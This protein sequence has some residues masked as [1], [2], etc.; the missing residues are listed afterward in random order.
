M[1]MM[2]HHADAIDRGEAPAPEFVEFPKMMTH[3]AFEPARPAEEVKLPGGSIQFV[4][5][6]NIR[7]PPMLVQ[8]QDQQDYY[9]AQGYVSQGKSDAAAF[10]RAQTQAPAPANYVPQEYPKWVGGKIVNDAEEEAQALAARR[11]QLGLKGDGVR[12]DLT[13]PTTESPAETT[14]ESVT[15]GESVKDQEIAALKAKIDDIYANMDAIIARK[16]AAAVPTPAPAK[17]KPAVK[18]VVSAAERGKKSWETRQKRA[19]EQAA[20]QKGD[21]DD[22]LDS[23][24][25]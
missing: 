18:P 21:L 9:E 16:L 14:T 6:T 2:I 22:V 20:P 8:N 23:V 10:A 13:P 1:A 5:G 11:E 25:A 4:G 17:P 7:F 15:G 3:P 19:A 12:S 24:G